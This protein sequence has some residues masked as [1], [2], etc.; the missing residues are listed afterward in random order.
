MLMLL[1][2]TV[3]SIQAQEAGGY[4]RNQ[5]D[6]G[7]RTMPTAQEMADKETQR[8]TKML[9]LTTEQVA[10]VKTINLN[11]SQQRAD[12]MK[13]MA[14][15]QDRS[16]MQNKMQGIKLAQDNELKTVLTTE[17]QATLAKAHKGMNAE[18]GGNRAQGG[19]RNH[20]G[21]QR[22]GQGVNNN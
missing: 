7:N 8:Q 21:G 5:A 15:S 13:E 3:L 1:F 19:R 9:N 4:H 18:N 10:K 20:G 2:V 12:L 6:G 14:A 16:A 17:Q 22:G 11:Y